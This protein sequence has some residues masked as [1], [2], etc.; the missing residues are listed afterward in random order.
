MPTDPDTDLRNAHDLLQQGQL[1]EAEANIQQA[2]ELL[3]DLPP[4]H[5]WRLWRVEADLARCYSAQGRS[6]EAIALLRSAAERVMAPNQRMNLVDARRVL[7]DLADLCAAAG[8]AQEA[9]H[10]REGADSL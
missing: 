7:Y 2:R 4:D 3:R 10:W 9:E 8:L 5:A 1:A 6:E